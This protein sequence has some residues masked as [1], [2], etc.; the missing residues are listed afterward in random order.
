MNLFAERGPDAQP[1][2]QHQ[3]DLRPAESPRNRANAFNALRSAWS[4]CRSRSEAR[5][6]EL[7]DWSRNPEKLEQRV[8]VVHELPIDFVRT[9][10]ETIDN[11]SI[12]LHFARVEVLAPVAEFV[13]ERS[14]RR[15]FDASLRHPQH[16]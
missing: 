8:V 1:S 3:S 4:E 7:V 13:K 16:T 2:G 9:F 14:R 10:G 11:L 12:F 6:R 15:D 5:V